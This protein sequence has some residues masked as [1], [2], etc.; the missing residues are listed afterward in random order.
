MVRGCTDCDSGMD[1]AL[2]G[3]AAT[4]GRANADAYAGMLAAMTLLLRR[5]ARR[6]L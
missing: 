6:A 3:D 5:R 1:A 2:P 4:A